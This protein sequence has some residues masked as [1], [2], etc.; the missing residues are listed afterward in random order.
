MKNGVPCQ[1]PQGRGKAGQDST[2][3]VMLLSYLSACPAKPG[4]S[5]YGGMCLRFQH[6]DWKLEGQECKVIHSSIATVKPACASEDC[7]KSKITIC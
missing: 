7:V 5:W 6:S 4:A 2:Y 1:R 3:D